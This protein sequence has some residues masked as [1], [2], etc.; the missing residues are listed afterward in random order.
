MKKKK[1]ER[2]T[3]TLS[4]ESSEALLWRGVRITQ[5]RKEGKVV[6]YVQSIYS[7]EQF[8]KKRERASSGESRAEGL[9]DV[10][11]RSTLEVSEVNRRGGKGE[12]SMCQEGR[13]GS[14]E[15]EPR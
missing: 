14:G 11:A 7:K 9:P 13:V 8:Q 10:T 6:T 4:G 12:E 1:R 3:T 2:S 5:E 15:Y